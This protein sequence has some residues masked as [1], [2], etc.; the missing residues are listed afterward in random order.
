MK[1]KIA[2]PSP[3]MVLAMIAL[4]VSLGGSA[5]A[6]SG[7]EEQATSS[8]KRGKLSLRF[9]KLIDRDTTPFD[10][11]FE[12]AVG[13]AICKKGERM[14]SGGIRQIAGGAGAISHI[15]TVESG[16]VPSKRGWYVSM[17]SD[18]GGGARSDFLVVANCER[19]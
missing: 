6:V 17:N 3:A 10:G 5:L 15:W 19:K 4:F 7:G 14:I 16:P 8:A 12:F 1:I 11:T 13:H 18:L 9:G 2:R